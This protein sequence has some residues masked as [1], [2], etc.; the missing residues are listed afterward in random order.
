MKKL[1]LNELFEAFH[2]HN[3]DNNVTSQFDD[4]KALLGVVVFSQNNWPDKEFSLESRSYI[5]SSDNKFFIP[6][7]GGNSIFASNLDNTDHIRLDWYLREWKHIEYCYI[8]EKKEEQ[9]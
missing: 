3:E 1:T 9:K 4:P 7:K 6:G 5:F 8:Q 2:K